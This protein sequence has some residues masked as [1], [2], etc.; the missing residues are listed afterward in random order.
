MAVSCN[1]IQQS[2]SQVADTLLALKAE[3]ASVPA[4]NLLR[5]TLGMYVLN[6]HALYVDYMAGMKLLLDTW[7]LAD[8][9][10]NPA[11]FTGYPDTAYEGACANCGMPS[12]FSCTLTYHC[13]HCEGR[14]SSNAISQYEVQ[15]IAR[16]LNVHPVQ[17][18]RI[19]CRILHHV[20]HA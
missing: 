20:I 10:W 1:S 19:L 7:V 4:E 14:Y 3:R 5:L 13:Y 12:Q 16:Y 8:S 11:A 17:I 18:E 6:R 9:S 2:G 15:E